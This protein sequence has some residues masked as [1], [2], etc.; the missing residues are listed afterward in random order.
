MDLAKF[1]DHV[2][3]ARLIEVGLDE[4][5]P[6]IC[7]LLEVQLFLSPRILRA[8]GWIAE[9]I[10]ALQGIVAGSPRGVILA[11]LFLPPILTHAQRRAEGA[12]MWTS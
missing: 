1:Y 10:Y 2:K 3:L 5:F 11:R 8:Q 6:A 7:L 4:E 9:P 12:T